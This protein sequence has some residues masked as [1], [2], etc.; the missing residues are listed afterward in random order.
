MSK[1]FVALIFASFAFA[2]PI[3][4]SSIQYSSGIQ[5]LA[6]LLTFASFFSVLLV[7]KHVYIVHRR[8]HAT[9]LQNNVS[10]GSSIDSSNQSKSPFIEF[11]K[12]KSSKTGFFVGF[13][14]SPTWETSIYIPSHRSFRNSLV[15]Q[16]RS[17]WSARRSRSPSHKPSLYEFGERRPVSKART[18]IGSALSS[19]LCATYP[20]SSIQ[21]PRYP[22]HAQ[23]SRNRRHSLP[24]VR[25]T[26]HHSQGQPRSRHTSLRSNR[27]PRDLPGVRVVPDLTYHEAP[28]PLSATPSS[29]F[30]FSSSNSVISSTPRV[31]RTQCKSDQISVPPLPPLPS[32]AHS[33]HS[34]E[35]SSLP[36]TNTPNDLPNRQFSHPY[37]LRSLCTS[38]FGDKKQLSSSVTAAAIT[39][40]P[41]HQQSI[42][43]PADDKPRTTLQSPKNASTLPRL[44]TATRTPSFRNR[45]SP[46]LGPSPLRIVTL[47]ELS[48]SEFGALS[49]VVK[50]NC[51]TTAADDAQELSVSHRHQGVYP[52]IGMGY[53]STWTGTASL[54]DEGAADSPESEQRKS[55]TTSVISSRCGSRIKHDDSEVMLEIIR[56][57]VEETS[58]WDQSLR[59]EDNFKALI[60]SAELTPINS[61]EDMRDSSDAMSPKG[62]PVLGSPVEVSLGLLDLDVY[63]MQR[64]LDAQPDAYMNDSQLATLEEEDEEDDVAIAGS[65]STHVGLAV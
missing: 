43:A 25:Q 13:F 59:M 24:T 11:P 38:R 53:P 61:R 45:K 50:S 36:T 9:S 3:P 39:T 63:R 37:A 27:S 28:L 16:I 51:E 15:S 40:A 8:R 62:S 1:F 22:L 60:R 19:T 4:A 41:L 14:G 57:L 21:S 17:S 35:I 54:P 29:F 32:S 52:N 42:P 48:I 33:S 46:V 55:C 56:D 58:Q 5:C 20:S 26:E 6:I 2:S 34:P 30:D 12:E 64:I 18:D 10:I 7:A 47:P 23:V 31:K 49:P 44:K 65:N